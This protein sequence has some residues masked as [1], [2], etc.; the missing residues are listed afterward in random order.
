MATRSIVATDN[1]PGVALGT[2]YD[3]MRVTSGTSYGLSVAANIATV[4]QPADCQC[5]L[6]T[7]SYNDDQYCKVRIVAVVGGGSSY[8]QPMVQAR[9]SRTDAGGN[10]LY[11][12]SFWTDGSAD[13]QAWKYVNGTESDV[14]SAV[15]SGLP[16]AGDDMWIELVGDV[17]TIYK[18]TTVVATRT[19]GSSLTTGR[20]GPGGNTSTATMSTAEYGNMITSG[21]TALKRNAQLNGLGASGPFFNNPLG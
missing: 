12:Y 4:Q 7:G 9:G 6:N 14:G 16:G 2:Q 18:N 19:M 21:G 11:F 8:I 13:G 10:H 1:F 5:C 15:T 3:V 17:M 20:P